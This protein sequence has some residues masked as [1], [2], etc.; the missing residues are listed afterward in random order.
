VPVATVPLT[1][2]ATPPVMFARPLMMAPVQYLALGLN[3]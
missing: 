3:A 2:P 1:R